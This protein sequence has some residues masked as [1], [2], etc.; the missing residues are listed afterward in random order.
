MTNYLQQMDRCI[1]WTLMFIMLN[2]SMLN[3]SH[4]KQIPYLIHKIETVGVCVC[5]C[6]FHL[7]LENRYTNLHQT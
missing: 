6:F 7:W 5:V 3:A 4:L 1:P 2:K